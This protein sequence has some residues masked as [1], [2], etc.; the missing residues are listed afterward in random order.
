MTYLSIKPVGL[1]IAISILTS[2]AGPL[3]QQIIP[4]GTIAPTASPAPTGT[5]MPT[6]LLVGD[7]EVFSPE[8]MRSDLND[9]FHMIET[10]HPNPFANRSKAE[11]DLE[12]QRIYEELSQPMTLIEYFRKIS[13]LIN[14]LGDSHTAVGLPDDTSSSILQ[15]ELFFPFDVQMENDHA[16]IVSIYTDKSEA[17]LGDELLEVNGVPILKIQEEAKRYFPP[18]RH[19]NFPAFWLLFGSLPEYQIKLLPRGETESVTLKVPG[20]A[21]LQ[22]KPSTLRIFPTEALTYSRFPNGNIGLLTIN[23]FDN[24][25][26]LV[27]PAFIDI[28]KD[29][30]EHLIIDI[31]NN[32][33]GKTEQVHTVMNYLTDQPYQYCSQTYT[34][35]PGGDQSSGP[36][37]VDCGFRKPFI[38][39]YPFQGKIYLLI[40]PDTFSNG[41]A[42]AAILQDYHLANLIGE[43]TDDTASGCSIPRLPGLSLSKTGLTYLL[44]ISCDVRPSGVIDGNGV[45]PDILV[46]TTIQ[47][48]L[49]G[50]D[51]VLDYT[52]EMIRDSV[53]NP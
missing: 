41:I 34:A 49:E 26:Q 13:P 47:D 36:R 46:K 52:L 6:F 53:Q 20:I 43:E 27:E 44:P 16:Y 2:C 1:L 14:S 8:D 39:R 40:G 29:Q 50:K 9:L 10:T 45:I 3:P 33:G 17:K 48:R 24:I 22:G 21:T 18:G 32:N 7:Y 23:N 25:N 15:N 51:P 11:V 19:I 35:A 31:R 38:T 37:K 42:F 30:I 5:P 4:T 12:R 28:Q